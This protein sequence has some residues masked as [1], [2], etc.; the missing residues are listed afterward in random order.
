MSADV[1]D[2]LRGTEKLKFSQFQADVS[3]QI[4]VSHR[5]IRGSLF[6]IGVVD[7]QGISWRRTSEIQN[8]DSA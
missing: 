3:L 8:P 1:F 2:T 5:G 4:I 6:Y 7:D